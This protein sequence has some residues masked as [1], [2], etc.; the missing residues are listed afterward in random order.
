MLLNVTHEHFS[1]QAQAQASIHLFYDLAEI[2]FVL[3]FFVHS[4]QSTS[5]RGGFLWSFFFSFIYPY[6]CMFVLYMLC[7]WWHWIQWKG[8]ELWKKGNVA[9]IRIYRSEMCDVG[10]AKYVCW[11]YSCRYTLMTISCLIF[12]T[13]ALL[14]LCPTSIRSRLQSTNPIETYCQGTLARRWSAFSFNA[15]KR[16]VYV[17]PNKMKEKLVDEHKTT[18]PT[19]WLQATQWNDKI[20]CD[21]MKCEVNLIILFH[22]F[23][24]LR[25]FHFFVCF[26]FLFHPTWRSITVL[27]LLWYAI[28]YCC[29]WF[30]YLF[31]SLFF[32][33]LLCLILY[34]KLLHICCCV[35]YLWRMFYGL[36]LTA[37]D[38]VGIGC[39]KR[40]LWIFYEWKIKLFCFFYAPMKAFCL[41]DSKI[42]SDTIFAWR[43]ALFFSRLFLTKVWELRDFSTKI[44]TAKQW[45][46]SFQ[47]NF[48]QTHFNFC[49]QWYEN[50][51]KLN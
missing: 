25:S 40:K 43:I 17:N 49:V 9:S 18:V 45:V 30:L 10:W 21:H 50:H 27:S 44:S 38:G 26:F 39:C 23:I 7:V 47:K 34:T 1:A 11:S 51:F 6:S 33:F 19:K 37:D 41:F 42:L 48:G 14:P 46:L 36:F 32:F 12:S 20:I 4:S 2:H 8:K 5:F 22:S 3:T 29:Y 24:C 15:F 28:I 16:R 31:L 13:W 35:F